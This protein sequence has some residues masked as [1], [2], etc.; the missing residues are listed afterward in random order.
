[1][2]KPLLLLLLFPFFSF[3]QNGP[4]G[5]GNRTGSSFLDMW[6]EANDLDADGIAEG[7]GES[8][9]VSGTDIDRWIDKS[10]NSIIATSSPTRPKV[11]AA[12]N[13]GYPRVAFV[14]TGYFRSGNIPRSSNETIFCV[15]TVAD[16]GNRTVYD[17]G[18][19]NIRRLF[20]APSGYPH[21]SIIGAGGQISNSL[22]ALNNTIITRAVFGTGAG[23]SRLQVNQNTTGVTGNAGGSPNNTP[24]Y[25]GNVG[26]AATAIL[27]G[28]ISEIIIY[29]GTVNTAQSIIIHNYLSAKYNISLLSLD[30]YKQDD[31]ANGNFDHDVAGIGRTNASNIQSNSRGTGIVEISN[32]TGMGNDE[33]LLW[34]HNS[35]APTLTETTDLPPTITHR[36]VRTWRANEVNTASSAV[37][38]GAIDISWDLSG[39]G[40]YHANE[41]A[42]LIDTDNDGNFSDETA[43]TSPTAMGGNVFKFNGVTALVNNAR[44]TLGLLAIPVPVKLFSFTA[45]AVDNALVKLNWQTATEIDN[46][47][48][49]IEHSAEGYHWKELARMKGAGNS[50]QLL[51]YTYS[52]NN[53]LTGTSYYRLKQTDMDGHY[54]YS[55]VRSVSIDRRKVTIYPNPV[56][57]RL[58]IEGDKNELAELTIY[59]AMGRNVTTKIKLISSSSVKKIIDMS[60]LQPGYYMIKTKTSSKN[61]SKQ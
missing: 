36:F 61:I 54:T 13:N 40:T 44:F 3:A 45:I 60:T 49:S 20:S 11:F 39:I 47:Y 18:T 59:D 19:G 38:I 16:A 12:G 55:A 1:M 34:G 57:N 25:I 7:S 35:G 41:I 23:N 42:L 46:D 37:D 21:V 43:I 48:F 10:G 6:F 24:L 29:S 27:N 28:N 2:K 22:I 30:L 53:P 52:D 9:L 50:S 32:A 5:V 51:W 26:S 17:A 56:V 8:V 15:S 33:Y 4:G 31:A 14:G 58:I